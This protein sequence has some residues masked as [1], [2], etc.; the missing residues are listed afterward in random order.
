[1]KLPEPTGPYVTNNGFN[2]EIGEDQLALQHILKCEMWIEL[3]REVCD[4]IGY[5]R[6][7]WRQKM[8]D[9]VV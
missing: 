8:W 2:G 1:M 5:F 7:H 6:D 4:D 9:S 3:W